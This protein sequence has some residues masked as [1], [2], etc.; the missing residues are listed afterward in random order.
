M[1]HKHDELS[2]NIKLNWQDFEN[3]FKFKKVLENLITLGESI[4]SA[5]SDFAAKQNAFNDRMDTAV[6]GLQGDIKA[7]N[8]EI[9]KLQDSQGQL[10]AE[11][12]ASLDLLQERGLAI[13]DKLDALDALTP[14]VPPVA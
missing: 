11:D 12:Q 8:D 10:S 13:S 2:L 6:A 7:L 9:K 5:V 3:F 14:P 4:M 1:T